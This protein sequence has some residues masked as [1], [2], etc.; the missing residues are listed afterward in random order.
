MAFRLFVVAHCRCGFSAGGFGAQ[1]KRCPRCRRVLRSTVHRI[2]GFVRAG[3]R[4]NYSPVI[5]KAP[6]VL[7]CH[8]TSDVFVLGETPCVNIDRKRGGVAVAALSEAA[9]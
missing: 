7:G 9:A 8:I 1:P 5:G 4:V 2:P 6:Q 3:A